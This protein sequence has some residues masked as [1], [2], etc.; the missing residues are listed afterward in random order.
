MENPLLEG[1]VRR[2]LRQ[3]GEGRAEFLAAQA[4]DKI[5]LAYAA[6]AGRKPPALARRVAAAPEGSPERALQVVREIEA[7]IANAGYLDWAVRRYAARGYQLE[8]LPRVADALR[9]FDRAKRTLQNKDVNQ[10]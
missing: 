9:A 8:D 10:F 1:L 6:D 2:A 3:L 4:T 5:L 7:G